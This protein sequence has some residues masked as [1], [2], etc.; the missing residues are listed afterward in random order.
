MSAL[1]LRVR[2]VPEIRFQQEG[3]LDWFWHGAPCFWTDRSE[4][5]FEKVPFELLRPSAS[6]RD[7]VRV[8]FWL[9]KI[10]GRRAIPALVVNATDDGF[11]FVQDGNHRYTAMEQLRNQ[12]LS[13][14]VLVAEV[15]PCPGYAFRMSR[16]GCR[17]TGW[18]TTYLMV[19]SP[20]EPWN[21]VTGSLYLRD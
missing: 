16:L 4:L 19:R 17:E 20:Q 6:P 15:T 10:Q 5:V 18:Y 1:S 14:R 12:G 3:A 2:V 8:A 9:D 11:Y 21:Q 13:I 7:P